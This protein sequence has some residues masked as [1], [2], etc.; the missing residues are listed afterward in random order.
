MIGIVRDITE[1][2]MNEEEYQNIFKTSPEG[3]IHI[4][5]EGNIKNINE[6]AT[7]ILN[8]DPQK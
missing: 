1:R 3:I 5:M 7:N 8:V 4:D 2:R 6:S